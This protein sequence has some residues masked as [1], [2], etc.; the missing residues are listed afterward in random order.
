MTDLSMTRK[1]TTAVWVWLRASGDVELRDRAP[2]SGDY[3]PRHR[4]VVIGS[5]LISSVPVTEGTFA[6]PD[7]GMHEV[8]GESTEKL[9]ALCEEVRRIMTTMSEP[10]AV[11]MLQEA[12]DAWGVGNG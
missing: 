6:N 4:D 3:T 11:E 7:P 8:Y 5:T 9:K 12:L 1:S 10:A 2:Y